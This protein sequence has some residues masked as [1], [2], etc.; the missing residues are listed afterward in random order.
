MKSLIPLSLAVLAISACSDSSPTSSL[1]PS[2][3]KPTDPVI[4]VAGTLTNDSFT[5]DD[6]T[7][8]SA[9]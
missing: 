9:A 3:A 7:F 6:G 4:S 2:Y 8:S 5:F 1:A